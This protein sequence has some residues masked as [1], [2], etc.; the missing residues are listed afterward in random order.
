[1]I[2]LNRFDG[3]MIEEYQKFDYYFD[4]DDRFFSVFILC[5][6]N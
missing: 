6:G 3:K 1:M 4:S 5:K 2:L